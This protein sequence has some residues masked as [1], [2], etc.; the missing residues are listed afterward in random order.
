M[1]AEVVQVSIQPSSTNGFDTG[2]LFNLS[3]YSGVPVYLVLYNIA[4]QISC[5]LPLLAT[6]QALDQYENPTYG[7]V[8]IMLLSNGTSVTGTGLVTVNN[9]T[10]TTTIHNSVAEYVLLFLNDTTNSGLSTSL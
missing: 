8:Q 10:G 7:N 2:P 1:K 6:I 5:D 3:F 9:G 4:N